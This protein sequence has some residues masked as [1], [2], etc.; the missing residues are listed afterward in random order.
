[1]SRLLVLAGLSLSAVASP[2]RRHPKRCK[3]VGVRAGEQEPASGGRIS[4]YVDG[5]YS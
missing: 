2:S 1:M 4:Y 5:E 3:W